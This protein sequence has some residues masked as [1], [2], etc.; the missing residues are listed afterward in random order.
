MVSVLVKSGCI[1][2]GHIP[3]LFPD[4]LLEQNSR[5][6]KVIKFTVFYEK[7]SDRVTQ[8][9]VVNTCF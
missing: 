8:N 4:H 7:Q 1:F 6:A 9:I 5:I 2:I 3:V